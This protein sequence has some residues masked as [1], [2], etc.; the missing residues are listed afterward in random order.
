MTAPVEM[1]KAIPEVVKAIYSDALSETLRE[2]GKIGVDAAKTF[3]LA[4]FPLQFS[5]ALQDRLAAYIN[6]A[7]RT[8]PE[9]RR[10]SPQQSLA[11]SI[12]ERL[13]FCEETEEV[14]RLYLELLARAMD[15]ERV[16]EAHPAFVNIISQLAPDE[17]LVVRQLG[18]ARPVG[19]DGAFK[20]YFREKNGER[21]IMLKS[22]VEKAL[23]A[24]NLPAE[25][26]NLIISITVDAGELAQPSLY[27]TFLEHLVALGVVSYTND[28]TNSGVLKGVM[29]GS[30][31]AQMLCIKLSDFGQLFFMACVKTEV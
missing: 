4:L 31:T 15:K 23:D 9:E 20:T 28:S 24:A 21:K 18:L 26:K 10:I 5:A 3:R 6:A 8:V 7:I 30:E 19:D 17:V 22:A 29:R 13:K 16:G 25:I 1:V 11:L 12:C 14:S 27:S 2:V